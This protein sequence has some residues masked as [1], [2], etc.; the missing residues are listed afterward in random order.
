MQLFLQRITE[1]YCERILSKCAH[2]RDFASAVSFVRVG[3]G[4]ELRSV[5]N[6]FAS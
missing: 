1:Q 5:S 2:S 4:C 6:L 3:K